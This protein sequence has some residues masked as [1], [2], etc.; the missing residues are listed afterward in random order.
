MR[1]TPRGQYQALVKELMACARL[2]F[3][4]HTRTRGQTVERENL[5]SME[6]DMRHTRDPQ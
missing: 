3:T 4:V 5:E 1:V 2:N 6:R